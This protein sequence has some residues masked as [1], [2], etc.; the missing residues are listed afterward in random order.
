VA[1]NLVPY[2]RKEHKCQLSENKVL[3]KISGP[4]K[5]EIRSLGYYIL[6]NLVIHI[7]DCEIREAAVEGVSG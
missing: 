7:C 2:L 5:M 6:R 4:S 1:V 3:R